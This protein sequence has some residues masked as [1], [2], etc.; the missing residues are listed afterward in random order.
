MSVPGLKLQ[1]ARPGHESYVLKDR[2]DAV[3]RFLH[4]VL[5][6][7]GV[8]KGVRIAPGAPIGVGWV[9]GGSV[10]QPTRLCGTG[11]TPVGTPEPLVTICHEGGTFLVQG[12]TFHQNNPKPFVSNGLL[13]FYRCSEV[14]H[15][16]MFQLGGD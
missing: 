4:A 11:S 7:G 10:R 14:F 5:A 12:G 13:M 15:M 16:G 8:L 6:L 3:E 1:E 9:C 2:K